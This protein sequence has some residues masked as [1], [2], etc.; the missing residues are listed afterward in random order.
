MFITIWK[1][2]VKP[3]K[4]TEFEELYGNKGDWVKLFNKFP[5]YIKTDLIK[6]LN[7][8]DMYLTMDYWLSKDA[9]DNFKLKSKEEFVLIDKKG[10]ELTIEEEHSGEFTAV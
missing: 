7:D 6:N 10:E 1:Y 9:Y 4:K 3:G 2:K 8:N 5:G